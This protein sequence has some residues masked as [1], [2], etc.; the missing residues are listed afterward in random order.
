MTSKTLYNTSPQL[1]QSQTIDKL[2]S[3]IYLQLASNTIKTLGS[4]LEPHSY[5][6]YKLLEKGSA[7]LKQYE[8]YHLYQTL[9]AP[10][11]NYPAEKM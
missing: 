8:L 10:E 6:A 1:Y 7:E 5:M 9:T 2:R 11:L 3:Q 4:E